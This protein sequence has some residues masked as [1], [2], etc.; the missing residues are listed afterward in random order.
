[1]RIAT[2]RAYLEILARF[3]KGIKLE[4]IDLLRSGNKSS[5]VANK[6]LLIDG[7]FENLELI[8]QSQLFKSDFEI[9]LKAPGANFLHFHS[10]CEQS[11]QVQIGI[12]VR[13]GDFAT[14]EGGMHLL[15]VGYYAKA[16]DIATSG[17]NSYKIWIFTDEP[18]SIQ[19][20]L[21]LDSC[22]EVVSGSY[23]MTDSEEL[24]ALSLMNK[25]ITS[26]ST[27]SQWAS[28]FSKAEIL[29][30]E[31]SQSMPHWIEVKIT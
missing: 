12:H 20:V 4:T 13:R 17:L 9:A 26:R 11:D 19:D 22:A 16:L 31:G 25:I 18:E 14:W 27:F 23:K 28:V 6:D 10:E 30:P 1:M 5:L 8:R 15:P 29:F 7:H 24:I 21:E 2:I 3:K